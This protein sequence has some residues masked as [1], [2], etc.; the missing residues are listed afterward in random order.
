MA[1]NKFYFH[2]DKVS[3]LADEGNNVDSLVSMLAD[4][5]GRS[6]N[7]AGHIADEVSK[8][9]NDVR[10]LENMGNKQEFIVCKEF[11]G[12]RMEI[13]IDYCHLDDIFQRYFQ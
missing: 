7:A 11:P 10:R 1:I 5:V 8:T 9:G 13:I 3:N 6:G 12:V 4:D 2:E